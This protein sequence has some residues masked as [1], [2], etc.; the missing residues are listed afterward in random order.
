M[1]INDLYK[2]N[3]LNKKALMLLNYEIDKSFYDMYMFN[4]VSWL[5]E[6]QNK[7]E[8]DFNNNIEKLEFDIIMNSDFDERITLINNLK[9]KGIE[10]FSKYI[11]SC[12]FKN[13]TSEYLKE[14]KSKFDLF[15]SIH[16]E[17]QTVLYFDRI[18]RR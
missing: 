14:L 13:I 5:L 17:Y 8:D 16:D 11:T 6:K 4:E 1:I 18:R 7:I 15:K 9:K 10:D 12:P 2:V 3:I